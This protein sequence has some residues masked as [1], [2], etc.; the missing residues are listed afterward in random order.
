MVV[1]VVVV[2]AVAILAVVAMAA[3][4]AWLA[5]RA[6]DET[7][8]QMHAALME[9]RSGWLAQQQAS[10]E[11]RQMLLDRLSDREGRQVAVFQPHAATAEPARQ[12]VGWDADLEPFDFEKAA[13]EEGGEDVAG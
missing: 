1:A 12:P 2:S 13:R 10:Q 3:L 5:R 11:E 6:A 4:G 8:R 9:E 7:R